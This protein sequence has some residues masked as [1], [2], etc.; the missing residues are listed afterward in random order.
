[1]VRYFWD[2]TAQAE[3]DKALNDAPALLQRPHADER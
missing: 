3:H 2:R 1:M